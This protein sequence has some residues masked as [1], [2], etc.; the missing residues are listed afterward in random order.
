M[1]TQPPVHEPVPPTGAPPPTGQ[2]PPPPPP[3]PAEDFKKPVLAE[4]VTTVPPVTMGQHG[5][6]LIGI[7]LGSFL[8]SLLSN[9]DITGWLATHAYI[10]AFVGA[11]YIAFNTWSTYNKSNI[12]Q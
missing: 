1:G 7:I 6:A 2:T 10:G 11:A 9:R 5:Q 4:T 12:G 8:G 3:T